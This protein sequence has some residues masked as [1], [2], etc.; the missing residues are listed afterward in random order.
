VPVVRRRRPT[1]AL[2]AAALTTMLA[3][4]VACT[5]GDPAPGPDGDPTPTVDPGPQPE[6]VVATAVI[7][8]NGHDV[9]LAVHPLVRAGEHV[10]LTLDLTP[11][12]PSVLDEDLIIVF[13]FGGRSFIEPGLS[14]ANLRLL[15]LV[16]GTVHHVARDARG[17]A[18]VPDSDWDVISDGD[19]TR[20]Q[21]AYA[22]PGAGVTSLS[23][24]LPGAPLVADV[25]VVDGDVPSSV[26]PD[27]AARLAASASAAASPSASPV[28]L[29]EPAA[30]ELDAIVAAPTFALESTSIELAG[31]VQSTESTEQ[32]E[33]TLGSDVLFEFDQAALTP[34]ADE[35]IALV[36][37][38]L[39]GREPGTVSVVGH[40][41]DQGDDAYNLDLSQRR[42]Q[43]VADALSGLVDASSYPM[44]V[45]GRGEREPFVAN[46]SEEGRVLNRRVTVTLTSTVVTRVDVT[47]TGELPPFGDRGSVGTGGTLR[48]A[49]GRS[50]FD[51][52]ATGRRVHGYLVVDATVRPAQGSDDEA[53]FAS[54]STITSSHRGDDTVVP[55]QSSGRAT[56]LDGAARLYPM[57]YRTGT[58][59]TWPNGEWWTVAD[60]TAVMTLAPGQSRTYSFVFPSLASDEVTLQ[61]GSGQGFAG[62][63]RLGG[64]PV[65][66]EED[67]GVGQA[68][69]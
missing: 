45:E 66:P 49:D 16:H 61:V 21:V 12:D 50:A 62:D 13:G 17:R 64:I 9:E 54:F 27:V 31:A 69:D 58:D 10:V 46:D 4:L 42:A 29:P 63:F 11:V 33:V 30:I 56:V 52:T 28:P 41:D 5:G 24:F 60:L 40:T 3:L 34:A 37:Q 8:T 25:P 7:P 6:D 23:L 44:Q 35:A 39:A 18:V 55:L 2:L 47:T 68:T 51:V 57:D 67:P 15:D 26:R 43:A 1:R 48:L 22:A 36:A 59:E 38:R 20:L 32:V 14:P 53:T 65:Q 19:G